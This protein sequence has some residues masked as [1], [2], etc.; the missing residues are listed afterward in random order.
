MTTV[1]PATLLLLAGGLVVAA[2]DASAVEAGA[3]EAMF[4]SFNN[5][6]LVRSG[7]DTYYKAALNDGKPDGTWAGSLDILGAEDAYE[8]TGDPARKTLVNDLLTTWLRKNPPPWSWDGW[9]DDIGWFSLALIRG[10]QIT[11]NATFL[12][13]ARYGFDYAFGRGWDTQYNGGGIWEENPEYAARENP[14][15]EPAKEPLSN[16][17]LGKVAVLIYQSTHDTSY[18]AKARQ[19]YDWV[20]NHLYNPATGQVYA[21][22]DRSGTIDRGAAA[23]NQGTFADFANLI[24]ESTGDTNVYNDAKKAI[25]YART[26]LTTNGVFSNSANYLNTWADEMARGAGH[27]VRDNRQWDTYYSW[28]VQNADAIQAHR[29]SDL[30]ITWNA[31]TQNTPADNSLTANKFVSAL[32]WLQYTP[33]SRPSDIGGIHVVTNQKTGLAIDSSGTYG[34]GQNVIQWGANNGQNQRWL[35]TRNSDNSWNIVNLA[36]WQALDCPAGSAQDGTSLVQWQ[37][38]RSGNQRWW[39][40]QQPDGSYKIWNQQGGAALDGASAT[41]DGAPLVQWGWNGGGQQRWVLR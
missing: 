15:R 5:A 32:A 34:N 40:D 29:R 25:D 19:I 21:R 20:W 22:I 24:H 10:Y 26:D 1:F 30:G 6:F 8:Q 38:T 41:V 3:A 35:F 18:L 14:P 28:M 23:Y 9:N 37:P 12:T 33:A 39:V 16:D 4:T 36:T 11:G 2:P 7:G 27:F 17:S 13:Q 31:W